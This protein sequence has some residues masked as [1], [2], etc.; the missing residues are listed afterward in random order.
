MKFWC[1]TAFMNTPQLPEVARM[2]DEA[3]YYGALISDH[4]IYPQELKSPYPYSPHPDGRP[5]W[6]PRRPGRTPGCS[7]EPWPR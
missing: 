5:I 7:S 2:L 1:S 6:S 3:G 4:V